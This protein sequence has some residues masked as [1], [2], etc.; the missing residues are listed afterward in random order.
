MK[1]VEV[2]L[3]DIYKHPLEMLKRGETKNAAL[4]SLDGVIVILLIKMAADSSDHRFL[5]HYFCFAIA[6]CCIS[7]R[8]P[9]TEC[10]RRGDRMLAD[11]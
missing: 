11:R 1:T 5:F 7:I 10:R 2:T 8:S 4:I 3:E 6:V 9:R